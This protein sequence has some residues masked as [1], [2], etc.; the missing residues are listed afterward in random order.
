[1]L[2]E[3][4]PDNPCFGCGGANPRGMKLTFEQDDA[5][6]R[7][8][9]RFRLGAEYCGGPGFI[10]GGII[11]VL[12]DEAMGKVSGFR[13]VRAV[14]AELVIE[15]VKFVGVGE[16][17]IVEAREVERN[18]R[19]MQRT[20]EIRNTSGELLARGRGRFVEIDPARIGSRSTTKVAPGERIA[21]S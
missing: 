15:Y 21:K 16:D 2:L 7:I 14:T 1:M 4:N 10:H 6:Q 13:Q 9:G 11:A 12:L 17:L 8:H 20:G 18:G 3:P 19:V 5:G